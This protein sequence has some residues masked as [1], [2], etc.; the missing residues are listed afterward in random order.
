M[1]P[2]LD[3]AAIEALLPHRPPI[4][5][6]DQVDD[7]VHGVR[8]VASR[9]ISVDEPCYQGLPGGLP[10]SAYAY[11]VPLLLESFAQSAGLLWLLSTS[12]SEAGDS[13]IMLA[14]IRD[15]RIE[16]AAFPGDVLRHVPKC[17]HQ[18]RDAAYATGETWVDNRR[19]ATIGSL[20]AV[21]RPRAEV[22]GPGR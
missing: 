5:L 14:G 20:L 2:L 6:I 9:T 22:F 8:L 10:G 11:P 1:S 16:S 21:R 17:G 4:L 12:A 15:C 3:R 13:V 7:F 18:R 19:I